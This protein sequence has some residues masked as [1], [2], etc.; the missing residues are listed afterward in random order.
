MAAV[1]NFQETQV[2]ETMQVRK[3]LSPE[4]R[5]KVEKR[6]RELLDFSANRWP[7][8]AAKF[9]DAP[10]IRYDVKNRFGGL[11]V[12][13]GREDWTIRLNLILCYENEE[14]FI[15][16]TVGHEVAH[17][18]CRVVYGVTKQVEEKGQTVTKKVRSHGK[19]WRSVMVEFDLKPNTYHTY[20]TSS[21]EIKKRARSK[22]GA[23]LTPSQTLDMLK[24]LQ[25][26]FRRL[27][28]DAKQEFMDWCE[29]R[30]LGLEEDEE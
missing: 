29:A 10:D 26:G 30:Q 2:A 4:L 3:L 8:H 27:D 5:V 16:H 18:V 6:V 22:R 7:E 23:P 12:S 11:A 13:G 25:T 1:D 9:Q 20:D 24:R 19:E 14:H 21:I 28:K 17:L 15:K